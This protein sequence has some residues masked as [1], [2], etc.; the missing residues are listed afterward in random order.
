MHLRTNCRNTRIILEWVQGTLGADLGVKGAG[1]G[2][3]VRLH[4]TANESE[5]A[6]MIASE[7]VEL[8]DHGGLAPGSVTVLSPLAFD[9]SSVAAMP[10]DVSQ[11]I[12]RLDGFSMRAVPGDT[13]GFAR[14]DEFKGLENDAVIVIDLPDPRLWKR[15]PVSL[16][17]AMSRPRSVL[18]LVCRPPSGLS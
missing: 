13:V 16:Y 2:S 7:I 17:V 1:A 4:T 9:E 8:V 5:S 12:R 6:E 10:R 18:S 15:D 14:V 3:D 11:R